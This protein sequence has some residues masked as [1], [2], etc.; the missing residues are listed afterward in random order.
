[1][2]EAIKQNPLKREEGEVGW[3]LAMDMR[4]ESL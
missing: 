2:D 4:G 1:M 3:G